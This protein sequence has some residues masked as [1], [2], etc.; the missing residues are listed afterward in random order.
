MPTRFSRTLTAA[1]LLLLSAF[2]TSSADVQG[3]LKFSVKN[4]SDEKPIANARILLKDSARVRGNVALTTDANGE[5]L[6]PPLEA[7]PWEAVTE[8]E[9]SQPD[10]RT[11]TVAADTTTEVEVLLE[12]LKE[13]VIRITASRDYIRKGDPQSLTRRD[14]GFLN[15]FP[16]AAGNPQN[17]NQLLRANPGFVS[18]SNNQTHPRGEHSATGIQINGFSLPGA[19]QGRAGMLLLPQAIQNIDILT[20]G[21]APE[22]G[23]ETAAILNVNL[24][25]GPVTPLREAILQGGEF[26]TMYGALTLG[27]QLGPKFGSPDAEGNHTRRLGYF[28]HLTG[29][30]TDNALEPPQPGNQTAHNGQSTLGFLANL[31]YQASPRDEL[32]LTGSSTPA[33]T[34][35]ANRTGLPAEFAPFGQG[36]GYGGH[37]T[38][39][40]AAGQN[41]LSQHA[42][43]QD[44]NQRDTNNFGTLNWR[45]SFSKALSGLFSVGAVHS[46]MA[47]RNNNPAVNLSALPADSS[48]EFNP[49]IIRNSHNLQFQGSLTFSG[50]GHTLKAGFLNDT[51]SGEESYQF[52]PGSQLAVNAL[53]AIDPRLV[54]AGSFRTGS[55][56]RIKGREGSGPVL[57]VLGNP[58]YDLAPNPVVPTLN[59]S[60]TGFYRAAYVQD[61]WTMSR[62]A[63]ANFGARLDWYRQA[64]NLGQPAVDTKHVSP[65][66]NLAY[67]VSGGNVLR[68]SYNRLF[69]QPPL[70]QGAILGAPIQPQLT[71]M[72]EVSLERQTGQNQTAK[73]SYF[74][75]DIR[76]MADT[77]LLIPGTQIGAYSSVSLAQ[78]GVHGLEFSWDLTPRR[79]I[80]WGAFVAY[81]YSTARPN[82]LTNTG[83]D[84]E[85]FTD[86]D[87]RHT[88]SFGLSYNFRGGEQAS[89]Q[90][91]YGSGVA[92]SVLADGLNRTQRVLVNLRL[93]SANNLFGKN[94]AGL[95][96]SAEN[97][98]DDRSLINFNSPFSGTRFQ[99]GR[100]I[101]L[102]LTGKF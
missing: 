46:G 22:Y 75:K 23:G 74:Y 19:L 26:G 48:I 5:A 37:L 71:N 76:N 40:E 78:A 60:R 21:F 55:N 65:R 36:F 41:I 9:N 13:K 101:L 43:G 51:Q 42:A 7:R 16:A 32:T 59:V 14:Q 95:E 30:R 25:G 85:A 4:A 92:S 44:I 87:Q 27:G 100:R 33:Y 29:R 61:T 70:A 38:A 84:T 77:G 68:M 1:A 34:Q 80:G 72:Y 66:L 79:N 83:E 94:T 64:Q 11:L 39:A 56:D 8:A 86:H 15:R 20:G 102:N 99:Q 52:V 57:D 10:T 50:R 12:P 49:T 96:L 69:T 18:N 81:A 17:F 54:P 82:G 24:R 31:S 28:L 45:H 58:I 2:T 88:L 63:T 73:V 53:A 47:I 91:Y 97:L 6:S 35:I 90:L 89:L 67:L 3:R 62:K 93:S 98:F